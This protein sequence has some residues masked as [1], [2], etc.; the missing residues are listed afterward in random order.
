MLVLV[1]SVC[2]GI[3][4]VFFQFASHMG[5]EAVIDFWF[6]RFSERGLNLAGST[7]FK[8]ISYSVCLFSGFLFA[9]D[10]SDD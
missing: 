9:I 10:Y 2:S 4:L 1:L 5:K 3:T 7:F 8:K 6:H